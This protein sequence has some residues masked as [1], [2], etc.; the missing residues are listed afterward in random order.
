MGP[1]RRW[2]VGVLVMAGTMAVPAGAMAAGTTLLNETF[3][4][5]TTAAPVLAEPNGHTTPATAG[6]PCLTAGATTSSTPVPGCALGSGADAA[7]SG[8]LRLT[9]TTGGQESSLVYN[10]TFPTSAG[11][12]V[13]YDQYQYDGG[14]DGMS[15]ALSVAP[16]LPGLGGGAGGGLGYAPNAAVLP[17]LPFGYLG[18]GF[19]VFGNY[20]NTQTDGT[21]CTDPTWAST[22][23]GHTGNQV[24]VRGPGNGTA[25]YCLITGTQALASNP[26]NQFSLLSP[27]STRTGA[28]RGI[29]IR[30][31][32]VTRTFS[33]GIDPSGGSSY[34]PIIS[35]ALP[36]SY[37][38]PATGSSV[39]GLPPRLTFAFSAATGG[40]A[41]IQEIS[42]VVATTINPPP[43]TLTLAA[44]DTSGNRATAGGT[45]VYTLTGGVA[46]GSAASETQPLTVTDPLPAGETLAGTPSGSGWNCGAS[47]STRVSCTSSAPTAIGATLPTIDV[48]ANVP[49]SAPAS[50]TNTATIVSSDAAGPV[51]ASDTVT[52]TPQSLG[53]A[54]LPT[55][56]T[57]SCSPSQ[58]LLGQASTC[59]DV[60]ANTAGTTVSPG[61]TVLFTSPSGT[62]ATPGQCAL[63]PLSGHPG[64]SSC[65]LTYTP[66]HPGTDTI[67]AGYE[68]DVVHLGSNAT[69]TVASAPV[70]G[71]TATVSILS[72]KI[73]I[74]RRN[75]NQYVPLS[76]SGA[77]SI[78]IGSTVD[79]LNGTVSMTTAADTLSPTNHDHD[80]DNGTFSEGLFAV[81]QAAKAAQGVPPPVD[82]VLQTPVGAVAHAKCT[83][84]GRVSRGV[85]RSLKGVV[86]G[87]YV[88]VGAASSMSMRKGA[89]VVQDRCDG[90]LT[91][92]VTGK[93]TVRYKVR[94]GRRAHTVSRTLHAGQEL[95]AK[96]RFLADT[97]ASG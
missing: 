56:G 57:L 86:K 38:N 54:R 63:S 30:I 80:A 45:I 3:R 76:A 8:V 18:I 13:T 74:R 49:A 31:D 47:V 87:N 34:T 59:T 60:V 29:H 62:F 75:S 92:V 48:A 15:F 97:L 91:R 24:V 69:T 22:G 65:S 11:L 20:G 14:A 25:G 42:N 28:Q 37:L 41:G 71:K 32:P 90:T 36:T 17:G 39:T 46:S 51:S 52:I 4:N 35:G 23:T 66:T 26:M 50:V 73:L 21:G 85:V 10:G 27:G 88:A 19:D 53:G 2:L 72:G 93:A 83:R 43:P 64:S 12:D 94:H 9:T 7:G 44:S 58:L 16:P 6:M 82:L 5:A 78:P 40:V 1:G 55:S 68:G 79:A 81:K 77:I 67:G 70:A 33:V 95:L 96:E 84:A 89:F 61:G